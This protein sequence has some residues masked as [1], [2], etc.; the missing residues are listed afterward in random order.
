MRDHHHDLAAALAGLL[1]IGRFSPALAEISY[2]DSEDLAVELRVNNP[3]EDESVDVWID[4]RV[5]RPATGDTPDL[6]VDLQLNDPR[7]YDSDSFPLTLTPVSRS[8]ADGELNASVPAIDEKVISPRDSGSYAA[9]EKIEARYEQGVLRVDL[10]YQVFSTTTPDTDRDQIFLAAET[11]D[12]SNR[13]VLAVLYDGFP[14]LSPGVISWWSN[15]S[16]AL[17]LAA[18]TYRLVLVRTAATDAAVGQALY[19]ATPTYGWRVLVGSFTIPTCV[20]SVTQHT[21][22]QSD[23]FFTAVDQISSHVSDQGLLEFFARFQLV[24][25]GATLGENVQLLLAAGGKVLAPLYDGRPGSCPGVVRTADLRNGIDL[26]KLEPGSYELLA[27]LTQETDLDAAVTAYELNHAGQRVTIGALTV[28]T[29]P[30]TVCLWPAASYS[31]ATNTLNLSAWPTEGPSPEQQE[32]VDGATITWSLKDASETTLAAGSLACQS[33]TQFVPCTDRHT[34]VA[35]LPTGSYRVDFLLTTPHNRRGTASAT[36]TVAAQFGVS[37]QVIDAVTKSRLDGVAVTAGGVSDTT[38]DGGRY[39]LKGVTRAAATTLVASK[40][41]YATT[42]IL[43]EPP[44]PCQQLVQDVAMTPAVGTGPVVTTARLQL[45][46]LFLSGLAL[47][48]RCTVGV[49]WNGQPGMVAFYLDNDTQQLDEVAGSFAGA[50]YELD[51]GDKRL[52]PG[53][54]TIRIRATSSEGQ[55]SPLFEQPIRLI[56]IPDALRAF[57][58]LLIA[59]TSAEREGELFVHVDYEF[60]PSGLPLSQPIDLNLGPLGKFGASFGVNASFDY[61]LSD[62]EFEIAI[63]VTA[64]GRQGKRGRRPTIPGLTRHPKMK[65]YVGNREITGEVSAK[66]DGTADWR[67]GI[68]LESLQGHAAIAGRFELGKVGLADLLGPGLST[69]LGAIPGLSGVVSNFAAKIY[70]I[71]SIEGDAVFAVSPAFKFDELRIAGDLGLEAAYEPKM[72][73]CQMRLYVGGKPGATLVIPREGGLHL[74]EMRFWAYAGA[75]FEIASFTIGPVEYVFVNKTWPTASAEPAPKTA[76][77]LPAYSN[78]PLEVNCPRPMSRDY[79]AAGPARFVGQGTDKPGTGK[80]SSRTADR[81]PQPNGPSEQML[82]ENVFPNSAPAIAAS[83]NSLMLLYVE[84]NGLPNDLQ[85]TD[86]HWTRF[87]GGSWSTPVPILPDSRAE[88]GPQVAFDGNGDAIAAWERVKD[89]AFDTP[90][91]PAMAAELEIVWARWDHATQAWTSPAALT[92]NDYL[93]H[94]PQICGP[95]QDGSLLLVWTGN[96]QNLFLGYGLPGTAS[97]ST[98]YWSR[99]DPASQAWGA[100]AALVGNMTCQL[101]ASL[102]GNGDTAVYAWTQDMDSDLGTTGDQEL[103]TCTYT[104]SGWGPPVQRT[105]N[106]LPDRYAHAAVSPDGM[107]YLAW[108]QG[109]DLVMDTNFAGAPSTVR[110]DSQ[111]AG[112]ADLEM[113]LGPAGNLVLIWQE[114]SEDGPDANCTVYDP[115]SGRWSKDIPLFSDA[116]SERAFSAVWDDSGN[117]TLAYNRIELQYVTRTV[118]LEGGQQLEIENVPEQ[119]RVDLGV[120]KC[121]VGKDLMIGTS[122][123]LVEGSSYLPPAE[124]KLS[125]TVHNVGNLAVENAVVAFY[126]G[127]PASGGA[128]IARKTISGWL[129]GGAAATAEVRWTVP[130]PAAVHALYAVADLDGA[131]TEIDDEN[132]TAA[133]TVGGTDLSLMLVSSEAR[134]DGSARIILSVVNRGV[135]APATSVALR[136]AGGTETP[137]ATVEAPALGAGLSSQVAVDLPAA[138]LQPGNNLFTATADDANVANDVDPNNNSTTFN[139]L[140]VHFVAADLDHDGDVDKDD[141]VAFQGC[142]SG[143]AIPLAAGC[144]GKDFDADGDVDQS[145]FGIFQRCYSGENRSADPACAN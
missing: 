84:D 16:V 127:D 122:D 48:N 92:N 40:S 95:L 139:V 82:V 140:L 107:V 27:V 80:Q 134:Q 28:G 55:P 126:D 74:E 114:Q 25:R 12:G 129:D 115:I 105:D 145:D 73:S 10:R 26:S 143:T 61:T 21:I 94:G 89:P 103:W 9:A 33:S 4:A 17:P 6:T 23:E 14:G 43:L 45:N 46:G 83:G 30:G 42:A 66:L 90:E 53:Q 100:L 137:I 72:G 57:A 109:E 110:A 70:L 49:D 136:P 96:T 60:P 130:E 47:K 108:L 113:T 20:P 24:D 101:S 98:V 31:T 131:H 63:G 44:A 18:G 2:S 76:D 91:L 135:G 8:W 67:D 119:G 121:P 38:H 54:H 51:M 132:N 1:V 41:G 111:T 79:R 39:E 64:E 19:E 93:D 144:G 138:I 59:E 3:A 78:D 50:S 11:G 35:P 5:N 29:A 58:D 77:R 104:G 36:F 65:L 125:A 13:K 32:P 37:G 86:I 71:P 120:L 112:F 75:S 85:F 124:L 123:F 116:A 22:V 102:A 133:V 128:E 81:P 97:N 52:T 68:A 117:L 69:S 34:L 62:G 87:D 118:T 88:F 106:S 142:A 56:A 141:Y 15:Q 7:E 99:W